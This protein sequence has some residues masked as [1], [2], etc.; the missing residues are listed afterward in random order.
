MAIAFVVL[1]NA[2]QNIFNAIVMRSKSSITKNEITTASGKQFTQK[3]NYLS[4]DERL[5]RNNFQK[6]SVQK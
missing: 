3:E 5:K 6:L 4:H 1:V 2:K